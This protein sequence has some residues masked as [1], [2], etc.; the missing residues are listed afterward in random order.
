MTKLA[1]L[2]IIVLLWSCGY[3]L[4]NDADLAF[5][6]IAISSITNRSS[7]PDIED[8]LYGELVRELSRNGIRVVNSSDYVLRGEITEFSLR[9]VAE[10]NDFTSDYEITIR[11]DI[12]ITGPGGVE[13]EYLSRSSPFIESFNAPTDLN[14]AIAQRQR[15]TLKSLQSLS[16][17]VVAEV[18]YE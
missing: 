10:R 11:A 18:V 12:R 17:A 9:T 2:A 3:S 16:R 15:A 1:P 14:A 4:R 13:R 6:E 8:I 7:E 5:R